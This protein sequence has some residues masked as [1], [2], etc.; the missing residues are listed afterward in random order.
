M[1]TT[2]QLSDECTY[3]PP[4]PCISKP[5][6]SI[7]FGIEN[8]GSAEK[9]YRSIRP[10]RQQRSNE[11]QASVLYTRYTSNIEVCR[12][13]VCNVRMYDLKESTHQH[14]RARWLKVNR[15]RRRKTLL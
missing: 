12:Q 3:T 6:D 11:E 13:C 9:H 5:D 1:S 10:R 14:N 8:D 7:T 2:G 4:S 15:R